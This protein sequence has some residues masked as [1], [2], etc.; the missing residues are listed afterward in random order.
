MM[1]IAVMVNDGEDDVDDDNECDDDIVDI[2]EFQVLHTDLIFQPSN[3]SKNKKMRFFLATQ[4]KLVLEFIILFKL[5]IIQFN[6]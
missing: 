6:I 2:V 4:L 1:L 5:Q 3:I